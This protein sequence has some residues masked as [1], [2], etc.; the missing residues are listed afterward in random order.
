MPADY[1]ILQVDAQ[2]I[3]FDSTDGVTGCIIPTEANAILLALYQS[4]PEHIQE[5]IHQEM[6]SYLEGAVNKCFVKA[7]K[8][9]AIEATN[10]PGA[11]Y[12]RRARGR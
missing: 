7:M 10:Y 1:T 6:K 11:R 8:N 2:S 5:Q 4:L 9:Y 12:P 3:N